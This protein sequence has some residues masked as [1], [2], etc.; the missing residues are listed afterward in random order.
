MFISI[1]RGVIYER[2]NFLWSGKKASEVERDAS[3]ERRL[4]GFSSGPETRLFH[5]RK[6]EIVDWCLYPCSVVFW[7]G[8]NR[9]DRSFE[10]PM[11]AIHRALTDPLCQCRDLTAAHGLSFTLGHL[12]H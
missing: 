4:F 9:A 10:G 6:D 1:R 3:D 11:R 2:A 5:L 12:R 7:Q 8:Y